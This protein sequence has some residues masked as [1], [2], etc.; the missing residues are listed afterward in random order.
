[1]WDAVISFLR[2]LDKMYAI[3]WSV[4]VWWLRVMVLVTAAFLIWLLLTGRLG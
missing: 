1:M 3:Q 4:F 2:Y